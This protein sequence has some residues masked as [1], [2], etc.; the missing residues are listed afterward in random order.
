MNETYRRPPASSPR[1]ASSSLAPVAWPPEPRVL[2]GT[3]IS[4]APAPARSPEWSGS[5]DHGTGTARGPA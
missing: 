3:A 2:S 4:A 5:A 1:T